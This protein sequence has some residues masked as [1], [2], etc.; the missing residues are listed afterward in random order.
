MSRG[1][2]KYKD[3][4]IQLFQ[5]ALAAL[6]EETNRGML[7][8]QRAPLLKQA[9]TAYILCG[10]TRFLDSLFSI[11]NFTGHLEDQG[12]SAANV[13]AEAIVE[14]LQRPRGPNQSQESIS[15]NAIIR[16]WEEIGRIASQAAKDWGGVERPE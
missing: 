8:G 14:A 7:P 2:A 3:A 13:L 15:T 6:E 4:S 12:S 16:V 10:N 1:A 5:T 9:V 11:D